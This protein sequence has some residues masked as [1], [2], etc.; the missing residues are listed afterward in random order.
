[1]SMGL[2]GDVDAIGVSFSRIHFDPRGGWRAY[3]I[4]PYFGESAESYEKK[5]VEFC[6]SARKCKKAQKSME[7]C[8]KQGDR[9]KCMGILAGLRVGTLQGP[10]HTLGFPAER[11]PKV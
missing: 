1:M 2:D 10:A 9:S 6:V 3:P 11:H 8:E 5:R 4:P 7:E